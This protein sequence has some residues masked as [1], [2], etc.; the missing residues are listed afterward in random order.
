MV[1]MGTPAVFSAC[2]WARNVSVFMRISV[3]GSVRLKSW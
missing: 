3:A 2:I 1:M